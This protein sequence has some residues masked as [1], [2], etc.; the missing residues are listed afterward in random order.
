MIFPKSVIYIVKMSCPVRFIPGPQYLLL[1]LAH[2]APT[3]FLNEHFMS[4]GAV[5]GGGALRG[6]PFDPCFCQVCP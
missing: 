4:I 3:C 2:E 6:L 5:V 1:N